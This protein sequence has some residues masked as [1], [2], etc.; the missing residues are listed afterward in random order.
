MTQATAILS[1]IQGK[2]GSQRE[3]V[4]STLLDQGA[5][6][7]FFWNF[8]PVEV[9]SG[10]NHLTYYVSPDYLCLGTDDDWMHMPMWPTTAKVWMQ[11]N[12][13]VL[14]TKTMVNQ[15]EAQEKFKG[16]SPLTYGS[17]YSES[18]KKYNRDSSQCFW[19]HSKGVQRRTKEKVPQFTLGDLVSGQKK[20]VV[21]TDYLSNP[22]NKDHVAI[23]GWFNKDGT[24]IQGM[25]AVD[26]SVR[27]VDYSH[28][29]RMIRS[30]CMLNGA[31]TSI[32]TVWNSP[33]FSKMVHDATLRF[34][35]Y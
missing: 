8:K 3:S 12:G 29:L 2:T 35:S 34:Q 9:I 6:P 18:D 23:Y 4:I 21:L 5:L 17:M 1:Q 28:G 24:V 13:L 10:D 15:I 11:K 22:A 32:Q 7:A 33:L 20:D 14:P 19:D 27:Y 31:T 25:N 30:Q 26:H 16:I